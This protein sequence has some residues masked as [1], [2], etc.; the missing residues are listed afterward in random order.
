M[1]LVSFP[2]ATGYV[3]YAKPM[4]PREDI[5]GARY[6]LAEVALLSSRIERAE[7]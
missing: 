3:I 1:A 6:V 2:R 4:D 5:Y 7:T